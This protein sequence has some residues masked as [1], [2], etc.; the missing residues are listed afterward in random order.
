MDAGLPASSKTLTVLMARSTDKLKTAYR[1]SSGILGGGTYVQRPDNR[2]QE[3]RPEQDPGSWRNVH[4]QRTAGEMARERRRGEGLPIEEG[5]LLPVKKRS[6]VS[7][8][9]SILEEKGLVVNST[10]YEPEPVRV[11]LPGPPL[12]KLDY[13]LGQRISNREWRVRDRR[14]FIEE[15]FEHN[16]LKCTNPE[17]GHVIK[18]ALPPRRPCP[19]CRAPM[20]T[21]YNRVLRKETSIKP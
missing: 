3:A 13:R 7:K 6:S 10:I 15:T 20:V 11:P 16:V 21:T 19:K 17:C 1:A 5:T 18:P 9:I 14:L 2:R 8:Y 12:R 4:I